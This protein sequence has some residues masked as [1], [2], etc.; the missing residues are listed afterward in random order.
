LHLVILVSLA[1]PRRSQGSLSFQCGV[2]LVR[3]LINATPFRLSWH[4]V[5]AELGQFPERLLQ[6]RVGVVQASGLE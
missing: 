1:C 4:V 2:N 6:H 3:E 5:V